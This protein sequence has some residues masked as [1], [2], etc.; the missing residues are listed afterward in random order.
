MVHAFNPSTREAEAGGFLSSRPAWST[1]W[2]PGQ[3]GLHRETQS[4]NHPTPPTPQKKE[5]WSIQE[6]NGLRARLFWERERAMLGCSSV[7]EC[8]L[9]MCE[10]SPVSLRYHPPT[11][12]WKASVMWLLNELWYT[13]SNLQRVLLVTLPFLHFWLLL[14]FPPWLLYPWVLPCF[15]C[16]TKVTISI[17]RL[18]V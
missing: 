14:T 16:L 18:C 1:K 11:P 9:A 17:P 6:H 5:R 3:P 12:K 10:G 15:V 7:V 8:L 2:V 13:G 4:R